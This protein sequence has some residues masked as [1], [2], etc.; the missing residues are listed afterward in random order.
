MDTCVAEL[1]K[2]VFAADKDLMVISVGALLEYPE[3][4]AESRRT[5]CHL[6]VPSGAIAGLDGIKSACVGADH[7]CDAHDAQTAARTRRRA[8][9]SR[10]R[11]LT[12]W[13]GRK[14][15][16]FSPARRARRAVAFQP[17][18]MLRAR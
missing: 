11:Y 2:K 18:L 9:L 13:A 4:M 10:T 7:A 15:R 17:M 12:G 8:L 6:Y 5:G 1:A 14:R 16:K 3:V